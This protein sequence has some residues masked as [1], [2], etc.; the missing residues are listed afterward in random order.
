VSTDAENYSSKG[1]NIL[2]GTPGRIEDLLLGKS[3][4]GHRKSVLILAVSRTRIVAVKF[5]GLLSPNLL[6]FAHIRIYPPIF[7]KN[8]KWTFDYYFYLTSF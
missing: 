7:T 2:V 1:G 6:L 3:T 4:G 8:M 5:S